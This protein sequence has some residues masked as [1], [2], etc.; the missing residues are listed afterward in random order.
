ME[1]FFPWLIALVAYVGPP[2][3]AYFEIER[4]A[5]AQKAARGWAC[6][7]PM[8]G[9][10]LIACITSGVMSVVAAGVRGWA[11]GWWRESSVIAAC[12]EIAA[13]LLPFFGGTSFMI[14]LFLS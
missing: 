9:I 6:G 12:A 3:W 2:I 8:L 14:Y 1:R 4:D 11:I 5:A 13:L 7:N 10:I